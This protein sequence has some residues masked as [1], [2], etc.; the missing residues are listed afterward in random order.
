MSDPRVDI[1]KPMEPIEWKRPAGVP[2][3]PLPPEA[4]LKTRTLARAEVKDRYVGMNK[5]EQRRAEELDVLLYAR[6][7]AA[8][9][10]ESFTFKMA[11]D[12][13]YT[14]DFV[15]Q[16][17]DGSLRVEE[18]KGFW[19]DDARGKVKVFARQFPFPIRVLR[20]EKTR[21]AIEEISP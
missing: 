19:R 2:R 4:V 9:W 1:G 7:I 6:E 3:H 20:W 12:Y 11:D 17:N 16:E 15:I 14:P 13:R 21:W 8:W 10:Y 18:T 5:T